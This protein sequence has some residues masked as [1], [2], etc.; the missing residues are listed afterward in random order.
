[1]RGL[2]GQRKERLKERK[3]KGMIDLQHSNPSGVILYQEVRELYI[4]Y[5]YFYFPCVVSIQLYY[6]EYSCLI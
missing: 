3:K 5:I 2:R 6:I 1:M 4:S